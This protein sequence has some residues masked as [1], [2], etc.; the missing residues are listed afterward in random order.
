MRGIQ[1]YIF[2]SQKRD[3]CFFLGRGGTLRCV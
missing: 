2:I 1:N 3:W